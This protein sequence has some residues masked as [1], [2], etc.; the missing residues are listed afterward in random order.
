RL[1][2]EDDVV[3]VVVRVDP[4]GPDEAAQVAAVRADEGHRERNPGDGGIRDVELLDSRRQLDRAAPAGRGDGRARGG[5][6]GRGA[7][8]VAPRIERIVAAPPGV[9]VAAVAVAAGSS[10]AEAAARLR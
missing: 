5:G 4:E 1:A 8:G 10:A 2:R 7:A 6:L 9:A 3:E